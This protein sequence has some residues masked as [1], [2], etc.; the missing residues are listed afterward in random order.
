M[1][2]QLKAVEEKVNLTKLQSLF[3][4]V[5]RQPGSLASEGAFKEDVKIEMSPVNLIDFLSRV[6]KTSGE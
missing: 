1:P 3:D 4:L 6:I 2:Q 5:L